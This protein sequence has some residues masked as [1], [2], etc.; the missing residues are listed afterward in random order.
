MSIERILPGTAWPIRFFAYDGAKAAYTGKTIFVVIQR[1]SDG[2]YWDGD[3][4]DT[5]YSANLMTELSGNIF[6]EGVYEY[7]FL[8]PDENADYEWSVKFDNSVDTPIIVPA[9]YAKGRI[10]ATS[11]ATSENIWATMTDDAANK[12]A[13]HVLRRSTASA[14]ASDDGDT[15]S[16]GRNLLGAVSKLVNNVQVVGTTLTVFTENDSTPFFTQTLTL[17]G[18]AEPIVGADTV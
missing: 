2:E 16:D 13:D 5:P 1:L 18:T 9:L 7:N 6:L 15:I 17:D 3:A 10:Q 4:F 8:S 11:A 12:I 14:R